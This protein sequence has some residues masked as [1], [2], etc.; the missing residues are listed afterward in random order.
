MNNLESSVLAQLAQVKWCKMC[1]KKQER[2]ENEKEQN[3]TT[4]IP[5]SLNSDE[6]QVMTCFTGSIEN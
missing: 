6:F 3:V 1:A 4:F 2:G 5:A